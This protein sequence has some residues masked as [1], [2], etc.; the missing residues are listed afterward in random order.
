VG[1]QQRLDAHGIIGSHSVDA[2]YG[3]STGG[4]GI[5]CLN[6][7]VQGSTGQSTKLDGI[8]ARNVS[9]SSGT[10]SGL[11]T[12]A[13]GIRAAHTV[14]NSYGQ[15]NIGD[16][17]NSRQVMN[18]YGLTQSDITSSAGIN[19]LGSVQNSFGWA[20]SNANG[21]VGDVVSYSHGE[22]QSISGPTSGLQ[23]TIAVACT[24]VG[25]SNIT[26]KYLMP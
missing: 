26:H 6:G 19:A 4:S 14:Q 22:R 15:A 18:C 10:T 7:S 25:G 9:D 11:S 17:I 2:S 24:V 21:I 3:T 16:G 8:S 5:F 20:T 12:A 1:R 13:A 23:A